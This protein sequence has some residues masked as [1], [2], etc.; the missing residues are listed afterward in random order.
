MATATETQ[1]EIKK[2][3]V[4]TLYYREGQNPH[5]M[6]KNFAFPAQLDDKTRKHIMQPIVSR[7]KAHCEKMGY[8]FIR[9]VPFMSSLDLDE[10]LNG[11]ED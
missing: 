8:R 11:V 1:S 6:L 2:E 3:S 5:P 10:R 7:A 4:F 9:V